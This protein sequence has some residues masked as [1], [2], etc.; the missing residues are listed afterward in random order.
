MI[1]RHLSRGERQRLA[2]ACVLAMD[3]QVV[4]MDEPTTG[5]DMVESFEIMKVLTGMRNTGKTILMV[6]HNPVLAEKFSDRVVEMET[7]RVTHIRVP[8]NGGA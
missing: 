1:P 6:T 3:Q 4:I 5:L 2:L 8:A 7:G